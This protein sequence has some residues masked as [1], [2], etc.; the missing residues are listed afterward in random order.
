MVLTPYQDNRH[1][2][3]KWDNRHPPRRG[4][5]SHRPTTG[6]KGTDL[7][8]GR[9]APTS[10]WEERHWPCRRDDRHRLNTGMPGTDLILGRENTSEKRTS[11]PYWESHWSEGILRQG[12]ND[13]CKIVRSANKDTT[14]H[15]GKLQ[16][17]EH[18][19]RLGRKPREKTERWWS[20]TKKIIK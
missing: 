18:D 13:A 11:P 14:S 12:I 20:W 4:D 17:I 6:M 7:I 19:R 5:D 8:L 16:G 15:G 9:Q 10:Y 1:R 2:T 3:G